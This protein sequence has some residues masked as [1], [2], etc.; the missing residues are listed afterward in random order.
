MEKLN[1]QLFGGRGAGGTM[2]SG[3]FPNKDDFFGNTRKVSNQY[4]KIEKQIL[5][6]DTVIVYTSNVTS[7][8]GSPVLIVGD[9][10]AVYLKNNDYRLVTRDSGAMLT[11]TFAVKIHKGFKK[12]TFRNN[13]SDQISIDKSMTFAD[14]RKLAEEQQKAGGRVAKRSAYIYRNYITDKKG[15]KVGV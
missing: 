4:I 14:F 15:R 12:Y 1:L 3:N 5:D 7:V 2:K 13:I 8:K 11:D 9:K 6:D 10:E